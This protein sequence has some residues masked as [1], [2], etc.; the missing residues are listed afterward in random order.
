[1][2]ESHKLDFTVHSFLLVWELGIHLLPYIPPTHTPSRLQGT[3]A[4]MSP[5][6]MMYAFIQAICRDFASGATAETMA[7]WQEKALSVTM[8]FKVVE[9]EDDKQFQLLQ[10]RQDVHADG[11]AMTYTV[12]QSIYDVIS[13]RDRKGGILKAADLAK[14]Y[15][16]HVQ[17]CGDEKDCPSSPTFV[18]AAFVIHKRMLCNPAIAKVLLDAQESSKKQNPLG[19]TQTC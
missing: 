9:K 12:L 17:W 16:A 5:P 15:K 6:E 10:Q 8:V 1:M 3:L 19:K 13:F 7:Q 18:D 11:I 2:A 14:E 4:R